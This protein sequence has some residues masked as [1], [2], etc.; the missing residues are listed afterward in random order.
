MS[1]TW[2]IGQN[3]SLELTPKI[4]VSPYNATEK[5]KILTGGRFVVPECY[6]WFKLILS[7]VNLRLLLF[8]VFL[9]CCCFCLFACF[10]FLSY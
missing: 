10:L 4:N 9:F 8:L 3:V 1:S 2:Y 7:R 5:T 6:E